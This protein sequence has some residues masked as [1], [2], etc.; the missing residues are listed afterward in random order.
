MEELLELREH[1][2]LGRYT[3]ALD[4]IGKM[5]DMSRDDKFNRIGHFLEILQPITLA[6]ARRRRESNVFRNCSSQET[7]SGNQAEQLPFFFS[8]SPLPCGRINTLKQ[9]GGTS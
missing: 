5:E 3:D 7:D 1:V 9:Q 6:E 2:R 4:L 8:A